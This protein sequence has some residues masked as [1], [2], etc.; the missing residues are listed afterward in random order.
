MKCDYCHWPGHTKANCFKLIGYP[1]GHRMHKN[2]NKGSNSKHRNDWNKT[3]RPSAN[4]NMM[5]NAESRTDKTEI[6]ADGAKG[7]LEHGNIALSLKPQ[8]HLLKNIGDSGYLKNRIPTPHLAHKTHYEMLFHKPLLY[9]HLCVFDCLCYASVFPH[10]DTFSPRASSCLFL[11]YLTYQKG[12]KPTPSSHAF[13]HTP[14]PSLVNDSDIPLTT[15]SSPEVDLMTLPLVVPVLIP[16]VL[17]C[18]F[19]FYISYSKFSPQYQAFVSSISSI[20][21]TFDE[22]ITDPRWQAVMDHELAAMD[23]NHTWDAVDLPLRKK[24]IRNKW[25]YK[26]KYRANGSVDPFK[27]RL[28]AKGYTQLAGIDYHD[29]FS[30]MAK[31]VTGELDEEIYIVLPRALALMG[32]RYVDCS[33]PY[34]VSSKLRENGTKSLQK[35]EKS[36]TILLVYVDDIV[37]TGNDGAS[38]AD[39]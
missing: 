14:S 33:N 10:P 35:T 12:Y 9:S 23:S 1:P 2:Q 19:P 13:I 20:R 37:I 18:A 38:I 25:V 31:I 39:L 4:V 16:L 21:A 6:K 32:G 11:G 30:L 28:V 26:V 36:I 27:A 7:V 22:A 3:L 24:P 34:M 29:N 5:N 17:K 8:A 15:P